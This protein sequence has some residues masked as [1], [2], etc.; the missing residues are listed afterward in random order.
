MLSVLAGVVTGIVSILLLLYLLRL[1]YRSLQARFPRVDE[2]A[3]TPSPAYP[4]PSWVYP[5]APAHISLPVSQAVLAEFLEEDGSASPPA[6]AP[7]RSLF[8]GTPPPLGGGKGRLKTALD[9]LTG[10]EK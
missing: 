2:V 5:P 6:S 9:L 10:A 1:V 3:A 8:C 7:P 4:S